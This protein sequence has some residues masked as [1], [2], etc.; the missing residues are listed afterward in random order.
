MISQILSKY[1][2]LWPASDINNI[3]EWSTSAD[4]L[5]FERTMPEKDQ[6]LSI[7]S[8]WPAFFPSSICVVTTSN[9]SRIAL[10]RSV[11]ATIVNRFP[12]VIAL[13]FCRQHLSERHYDRKLFTEIIEE[14][15]SVA[16]QFLPPGP[17]FDM[18]MDAIST[19]PDE[20]V[21]Q[22]ISGSDLSFRKAVTNTAPVF[23][24]AYM[25]YEASLVK[26][27][28]DFNGNQIFGSP[29]VDVGSHRL[30]FFEV[31]AIQLR[32]DIAEG[33]SQICWRSLPA[34]E[35]ISEKQGYL[36]TDDSAVQK[37]GYQKGY[38]A[39]YRFPGSK[40][41]AFESDNI[42]NC[43]AVKHLPPLPEDQI[44]VDN[45][46][47]R[48][49]CFFPSSLSFVTT[50]AEEDVPNMM[51]CGSTMVVSRQ[52]MTIAICIAYAA[53]NERYSPRATL[54]FIRRTGK[55]GC[56]VPFIHENII[57]AIQYTGNISLT[58][59]PEKLQH[60]G[61][62]WELTKYA[63]ALSALPI[64]YECRVVDEI[65]LGTHSMF[66]GEVRGIRVRSDVT[67]DNPLEWF[68][69]AEVR[70]T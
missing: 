15:E 21:H 58:D 27:G 61:L 24:D 6:E 19:I 29:W 22:R 42:E 32:Q 10:E 41:T 11:G 43:M 14:N 40:T 4:N 39:D 66:L 17:S 56:G 3:K 2:Y 59:D 35:P 47:A 50:L 68:P 36:T 31:N 53:I 20:N 60:A 7:D 38:T 67:P 69:L 54:D 65:R 46:R 16:V 37:K 45:D 57:S 51:P 28:K 49:P 18:V 30:Y 62:K 25:V 52:P 12:Y 23:S 70:G 8:R 63:P 5:F 34:W 64:H 1:R 55:F 26:P 9:G 48:W 33:K 44:E 13:S